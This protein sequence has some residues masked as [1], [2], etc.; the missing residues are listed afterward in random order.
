MTKGDAV[1]AA[2]N[3]L[4][5]WGANSLAST[6]VGSMQLNWRHARR[7]TSVRQSVRL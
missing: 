5:R 1:S 2:V 6:W 7:D 4:R 3:T